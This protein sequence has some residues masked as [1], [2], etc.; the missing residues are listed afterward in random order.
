MIFIIT[1]WHHCKRATVPDQA[2]M[3]LEGMDNFRKSFL[4]PVVREFL[5]AATI[6]I[7]TLTYI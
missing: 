7:Y 4:H 5:N 3:S 2:A 6:P 1:I